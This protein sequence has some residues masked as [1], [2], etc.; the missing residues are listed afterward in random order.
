M[1]DAPDMPENQNFY[2]IEHG[3]RLSGMPGWKTALKKSEIWQVTTFLS[4]LNK[5]PTRVLD[6]WKVTSAGPGAAPPKK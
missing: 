1:E 4:N 5:L 2:I 3:I 6:E